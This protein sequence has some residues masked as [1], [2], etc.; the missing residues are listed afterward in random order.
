MIIFKS[1]HF[2][3]IYISNHKL[4]QSSGFFINGKLKVLCE[5][6]TVLQYQHNCLKF[7]KREIKKII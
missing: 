3:F 6:Y 5:E 1:Y 4:L 2:L 7:K